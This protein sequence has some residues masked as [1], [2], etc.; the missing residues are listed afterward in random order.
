MLGRTFPVFS[1]EDQLIYLCLHG[2]KHCWAHLDLITCLAELLLKETEIDWDLVFQRA[3][4]YKCRRMVY[5]GLLLAKKIYR[6][7]LPV[8]VNAVVSEDKKAL[9]W[10]GKILGLIQ[11]TGKRTGRN[12]RDG[13]DERFS[14]FRLPSG[15]VFGYW[16][17]RPFRVLWS[18]LAGTF[19][20]KWHSSN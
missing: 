13:Q 7:H 8:D 6:V 3:K 9:Y 15:I 5:I 4:E 17:A 20:G 18:V 11:K 19:A 1:P 14:L 12:D 10:C 2:T 16:I